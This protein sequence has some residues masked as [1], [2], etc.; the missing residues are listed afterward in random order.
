[1]TTCSKCNCIYEDDL[2][3]CPKC[4]EINPTFNSN[5]L[6]TLTFV[7]G[8]DTGID[9]DKAFFPCDDE[10]IKVGDRVHITGFNRSFDVLST[11]YVTKSDRDLILDLSRTATR[12]DPDKDY[13]NEV[14]LSSTTQ[15]VI[16]N[17]RCVFYEGEY[18]ADYD[19]LNDYERNVW[20][21]RNFIRMVEIIAIAFIYLSALVVVGSLFAFLIVGAI[22]LR[23]TLTADVI[24]TI[25]ILVGFISVILLGFSIIIARL[26]HRTIQRIDMAYLKYT[27]EKLKGKIK[28]FDYK[29]C[30]LWYELYGKCRVFSDHRV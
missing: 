3:C 26:A 23:S 14:Q 10:T 8:V 1:M 22:D 6:E 4:G 29:H 9:A 11:K 13:S 28:L 5:K 16:R 25:F 19:L 17:R 2:Q 24:N 21:R 30:I 7:V 18:V 12:E 15:H 27:I 20:A